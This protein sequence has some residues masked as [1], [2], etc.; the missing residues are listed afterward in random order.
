MNISKEN[1]NTINE[2]MR[3][4]APSVLTVIGAAGLVEASRINK[5]RQKR[6]TD[7]Y[8]YMD[9]S[10]ELYKEEVTRNRGIFYRVREFFKRLFHK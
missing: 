4:H 3:K 8:S 7:T 9:A 10:Y 1:F 6:L 5:M 2:A